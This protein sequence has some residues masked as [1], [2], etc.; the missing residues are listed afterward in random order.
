MACTTQL[1]ASLTSAAPRRTRASRSA[2]RT[3]ASAA[4]K[5]ALSAGMAAAVSLAAA[6]P[7]FAAEAG[8]IADAGSLGLAVG[9]T[10]AI[11]GLAFLLV[12]TDPDKRH[13]KGRCHVR[14]W[15]YSSRY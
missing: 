3:V 9:S 13:E 7:A 5:N 15:P 1:S 14:I 2:V 6:A 4:P 12:T 11:A 8:T 10:G